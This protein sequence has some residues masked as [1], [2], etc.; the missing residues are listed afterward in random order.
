MSIP[1]DGNFK[2]LSCQMGGLHL[3]GILNYSDQII[4]TITSGTAQSLTLISVDDPAVLQN[5]VLNN[6]NTPVGYLQVTIGT[7]NTNTKSNN[8]Y[9]PLFQ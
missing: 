1:L 3:N 8:Y 7:N 9:I 5:P 2:S 6:N 4:P